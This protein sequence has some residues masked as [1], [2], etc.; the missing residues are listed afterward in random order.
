MYHREWGTERLT[1]NERE[2]LSPRFHPAINY[3][4]IIHSPG[5]K[6]LKLNVFRSFY[7]IGPLLPRAVS[8]DREAVS[9]Y[10]TWGNHVAIHRRL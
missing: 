8:H 4:I 7:A 10:D 9:V 3:Y 1:A 2:N 6:L 5:L